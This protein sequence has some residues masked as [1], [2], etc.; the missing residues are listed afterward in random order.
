MLFFYQAPGTCACPS[1]RLRDQTSKGAPVDHSAVIV[2]V[3]F[4]TLSVL[5]Q[6]IFGSSSPCFAALVIEASCV[7]GGRQRLHLL[8]L[9]QQFTL[10]GRFDQRRNAVFLH[11][12]SKPSAQHQ[13][14][15]DMANSCPDLSASSICR[16]F[17]RL[18]RDGRLLLH[19][20]V[21]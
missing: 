7:C 4:L 9:Q 18:E 10:V 5:V 3:F 11:A 14:L 1:F 16:G 20:S 15:V 2:L 8:C 13:V 6:T 19:R 21:L 17:T 12:D